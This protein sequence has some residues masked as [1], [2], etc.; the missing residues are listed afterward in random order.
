MKQLAG[1]LS[2]FGSSTLAISSFWRTMVEVSSCIHVLI[3]SWHL[4][5]NCGKDDAGLD[6]AL[7]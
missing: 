5:G 2:V 7:T 1:W 4:V 6:E 3:G